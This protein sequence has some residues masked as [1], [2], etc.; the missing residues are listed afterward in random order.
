[1]VIFICMFFA[2]AMVFVWYLISSMIARSPDR[3]ERARKMAVEQGHVVTANFVRMFP[4]DRDNPR[5]Q[6]HC[7]YEYVCNG[8]TYKFSLYSDY[9]PKTLDLYYLRK[10]GKAALRGEIGISEKPWFLRFAIAAAI[11]LILVKGFA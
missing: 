7:L 6:R 2:A 3:Q 9:P 10:P 11:L 4:V 5:R 1:M 8:K